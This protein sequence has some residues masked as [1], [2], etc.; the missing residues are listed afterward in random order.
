MTN[1]KEKHVG[2]SLVET[3]ITCFSLL[4]SFTKYSGLMLK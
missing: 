4:V 3:K 2:L 1:I